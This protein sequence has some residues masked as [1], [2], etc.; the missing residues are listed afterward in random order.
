MKEGR[1]QEARRLMYNLASETVISVTH[2]PLGT[3]LDAIKEAVRLVDKN[4]IEEAKK[5][6]QD[7]LNTLVITQT[8]IPIPLARAQQLL[9]EA[10]KLSKDK[11]SFTPDKV[12]KIVQNARE[13]LRLAEALGYGTANDFKA[14]YKHLAQLEKVTSGGKSTQ[15]MFEKVRLLVSDLYAKGTSLFNKEQ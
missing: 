8:I 6:L 11:E 10:E 9:M 5:V 12:N 15:D 1:I 3:Y 2:L 14:L 4:Q 7:A 13:D